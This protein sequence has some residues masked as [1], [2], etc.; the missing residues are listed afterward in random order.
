MG[1]TRTALQRPVF[2]LMLM[3]AAFV[4][5]TLSYNSMTKELNPDIS[6]GLVSISTSYPGASP[7]EVNTLVT[8]KIEDGIAGVEGIRQISSSSQQGNSV[9]SV[10]FNLNID[11]DTAVNDVRAKIDTVF[12]QLPTE[13]KQPIVSK[14]D[15]SSLPILYLAFSA[16]GTSSRDLRDLIDQQISDKFSQVTGVGQVVVQGGDIREIQVQLSKSKLLA[17]GIGI[18]D[19]QSALASATQNVPAGHFTTD[20]QQF[21]VRVFGEFQS[22]DQI[23][24]MWLNISDPKNPQ[25]KAASVQLMDIATVTD[26]VQ[27]RTQFSQVNGQ[28][29]ILMIIQK[30]KDG[31]TV[32]AVNGCKTVETQVENQYKDIGLK[33]VT[34]QDT[35]Q[36]IKD[37][38]NDLNFTLL[39]GIILVALIVYMFL[40]NFRGTII[41]A[42]AIPI[43]IFVTFIVLKITGFSINNLTMLA[44]S[45]SIGV[46][47][48]DAIV[49]IENI[50]RHLQLG[51]DPREAALNG[52]AEIGLAAIS[53]TLADVV[54]FLPIGFSGGVVGEFLRPLAFGYVYATLTSLFVSFTVTPMLASRWYRKGE[55][56]EH[57]T[58]WFAR[59][60]DRGFERFREGYKRA[61]DWSLLH[62]WFVFVLGNIVLLAVFMAIAGSTSTSMG[63][64]IAST[65]PLI[66]ISVIIGIIAVV[67]NLVFYRRLKLLLPVYA[68]LFSLLFPAAAIIG[69][70]AA[71]WKGQDLFTFQFF[72]ASDT[73]QLAISIELPPDANLAQTTQIV[74]QIQN[75]IKNSPD[76][77][78]INASLGTQGVGSF[79]V[80]NQGPNYAILNI[81][82]Y[83]Q[84]PILDQMKFWAKPNVYYRSKTTSE[85][86][87]ELLQEVGHVPGAIVTISPADSFGAGSAIQLAFIGD[88][89]NQL[90]QTAL[91]VENEL[92]KGAIPGL[93]NMNLSSKPGTPELRAVPDRAQMADAGIT[94]SQLGSALSILYQGDDNVKFR[95]NG[96]EYVIRTM[97]SYND[98]ND[99]N[100]INEV[101]ITFK[102]GNPIFVPSV[103]NI[104]RG[105][106]L[107][108]IDRLDRQEEIQV[109]ADLLPSY[110]SQ[111]GTIQAAI[112]K[113]LKAKKM[114]PAGVTYR[115]LGQA[116]IQNREGGGIFVALILGLMLVYMLLAS[117]FNNLLYPLV[118]Q[119][120]Q[121]QAF[122]G[123][124]L[125]LIIAGQPLNLIGIIGMIA[126]IG[127]VGKNA[128][129]LV[130]YTNTLRER[131]EDRH[132]ALVEAGHTRIRPI[133]MTVSALIVAMLPIAFAIGRGSDFR[134]TIGTVIIGGTLLST[135]LTLL[136]I[137]CSYT[138]FDDF[139]NGLGKLMR[140][141]R[142]EPPTSVVPAGSHPVDH[143]GN[144]VLEGP[145]TEAPEPKSGIPNT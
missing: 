64:A 108:K 122:V 57:P 139:G 67:C 65:M 56:V 97:M 27:E 37:S 24:N 48:D 89:R 1:L 28:D 140:R 72:P 117:L 35:S 101:P 25:A 85:I 45:L 34:T 31:N 118:I 33:I 61:L 93:M 63:G 7:D 43:C 124:L 22:V 87:S 110:S 5:G 136:V 113:M 69:Y 50:F 130:D 17:Y 126:L 131:G 132:D 81:S 105:S 99:P 94:V 15:T 60:F 112:D 86:S 133:L 42:I 135:L 19:V 36:Q 115:P 84:E 73:G 29:A 109:N 18:S 32:D 55:N 8:K 78:F 14:V 104:V 91:N 40:H 142:K 98:R 75:K 70:Q 114:I 143:S 9:V 83:D 134:Q 52:R 13:A 46:L 20:T 82:L 96:Q 100:V 76:I 39:F 106:Q 30:S 107:S 21:N 95:Q 74:D 4:I 125:A 44:L 10:S 103:A 47:V 26:T 137:P 145:F 123:A 54:V 3:L 53:I 129:L 6:F 16:P 120:A 49:I 111:A 90:V 121:P 88:D 59:T 77:Q 138:I 128:I 66:V 119:I 58:G 41:V 68:L 71:R 2:I 12:P 116:D 127:L 141:L 62:R 92:K 102:Q 79:S 144:D 11:I 23:K 38:L 80:G 51:E